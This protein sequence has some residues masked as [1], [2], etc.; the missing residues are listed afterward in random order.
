MPN[1]YCRDEIILRAL[2]M[3]MLPNLYIHEAPDG[4]VLPTA[5]SIGWLQEI[6]D[7]WY[8]M[9]PFSATVTS[10]TLNCTA[11]NDT[12]TLPSDFI[13]DIRNGYV[14]ET[15]PGD[16][17]SKGRRLR[18]PF[19]KFLNR[20][21]FYQKATNVLYPRYYCVIDADVSGNQQMKVSPIPTVNV[22]G[23]IWYYQLPP[24][25]GAAD[26]PLFPNDYVCIEYVRIRAC[27]WGHLYDPGTAH[28]FCEKI[29]AGM[30][31][32]GL[33]NEPEDDEIPFDNLTF[34]NTRGN[35]QATYSWMGDR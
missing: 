9:V 23:E 11:N 29:V 13:L 30:K 26:K 17:K 27:E 24:L 15:I 3:A 4:V 14:T 28:K 10:A 2:N 7:F 32:A 18:L 35:S 5:F 31:A 19:Q 20:K 1:R 21:L 12:V 34:H 33:M 6:L 16:Q 22:N 25:L 8:H